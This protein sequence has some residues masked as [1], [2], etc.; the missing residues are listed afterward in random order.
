MKRFLIAALAAASLAACHGYGTEPKEPE[1]P[2][3][4]A[5]MSTAA[6][7]AQPTPAPSTKPGGQ[8]DS[9]PVRGSR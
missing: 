7:R 9:V 1:Q 5:E 4:P 6:S 3:P 2:L 8:R